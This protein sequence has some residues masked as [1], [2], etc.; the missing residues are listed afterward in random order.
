MYYKAK[1]EKDVKKV[2]DLFHILF[3]SEEGDKKIELYEHYRKAKAQ[4]IK[5]I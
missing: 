4:Q 5:N 3:G 1:D 2:Y